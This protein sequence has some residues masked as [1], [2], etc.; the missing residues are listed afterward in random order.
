[1]AL[2]SD[3]TVVAWGFNFY[4]Q[5][6]DGT[7]T[8]RYTPVAVTGL[9]GVDAIAAGDFHSMALK[10]DGTVVAWG[11][12]DEG[13]LGY[14]T[15]VDNPTPA[16]ISGLTGVV[17]ISAGRFHSMAL[18]SDGT[19]VAWGGNYHGQLGRWHDNGSLDTRGPEKKKLGVHAT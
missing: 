6:G 16:T 19:V 4:G 5:L 9:T 2:K 13:Q 7:T 8:D 11:R 17:A 18:K 10:S 12:N 1:M 14:G 3:G 15:T